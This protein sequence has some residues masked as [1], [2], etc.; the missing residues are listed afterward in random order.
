M[1][2]KKTITDFEAH[3]NDKIK[4]AL[5]EVQGDIEVKRHEINA[6]LSQATASTL[7]Q[8]YAES[9]HEYSVPPLG[10]YEDGKWL[11][12]LSVFFFNIFGRYLGF[13]F[14][15]VLFVLPLVSVSLI[16]INE[17]VASIVIESLSRGGV[18]PSAAELIY[19]KTIISVPLIWIA[20]YGHRNLSQ[21]NGLTE[22]YNHKLRVVQMYLMFIT[23]DSSYRLKDKVGLENALLEVI[24]RNPSEVYGH[25]ET[26]LDKIIEI[27]RAKQENIEDAAKK[28]GNVSSI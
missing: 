3:I 9:K 12:N 25:D 13:L 23:N 10:R 27:F 26:M 14:N 20:W 11:R 8:A 4:P 15:Y 17:S 6:L 21:R 16:F 2:S 19:V 7:A 24:K 18:V 22:E 1:K 5:K 28:V